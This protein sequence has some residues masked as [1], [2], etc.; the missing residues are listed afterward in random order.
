MSQSC[1]INKCIRI[2]RGLCDC[3]QQNLCLQHLI[4]HNASLVSQLNPLTDEVNALGDRLKTLNIQKTIGDSREKLEQWRE[5]CHNKIDCFFEEK[6]QE[7]DQLVNEKVGQQREELNRINLKITEL[8]N[9]QE[10]TR[11]DIDLLTFTIR[12]LERNMNK[13]EQ[14]CFTINTRPLII[15]DTLISIEKVTEHELDLSTLSP[16]YKTIHRPEE[17]SRLLTGND[18]Y[19]LVHQYPNLCLF[20]RE[21]NIVKQMLWS[22]GKINDMCWSSTLD[23]F[24]VLGIN[25]IYLINENTMSIDNMQTSEERLWL[26]CTCSDTVLFA[27]TNEWG[28]S[29]MKFKLLPAIEL[30]K[31]WKYPFTCA[32]DEAITDI[33]KIQLNFLII[34]ILIYK[35]YA[36]D[37]R[38]HNYSEMTSILQDLAFRYPTK[39]SLVEIGKSQGGRSLW[40]MT[41]SAYAPNEHILLRPEV[42][43]IGNMHGNE[44]VGLE[45]LLY[46][47]EYLLTSNDTQVYQLM[48]QSRIWIMPS[49][50]P[51]GLEESIY[52][53]CILNAGRNTLNNI[54]LNRNFPDYYGATLSSSIRAQETNAIISWLANISFVLSANYHGGSFVVNTPFDRFYVER[55]STSD[56]DDIYQM[57]AHSYINRT[58][59]INDYCSDEQINSDYVTRGADWYEVSGGMQDY[60]YFNYGT[61]EITIEVSCCKYP[62]SNLLVNYWNYNRDAMIEYLLQAQ[63]GVKGLILNENFQPIPSTQVMINNRKPVVKVTSLG[64]FWRILLPGTYTLKV[65]YKNIQIYSQE[66]TIE[67]SLSPLNLTIIISSATY[68]PYINMTSKASLTII[69][70]SMNSL[71]SIHLKIKKTAHRTNFLTSKALQQPSNASFVVSPSRG[72]TFITKRVHQ[73]S[74][75]KTSNKIKSERLPSIQRHPTQSEFRQYSTN[76]LTS[77]R[78]VQFL[79]KYNKYPVRP[80]KQYITKSMSTT[81]TKKPVPIVSNKIPSSSTTR[82]S[83]DSDRRA[84]KL[85][86]SPKRNEV[87]IRSKND[88][89]F[90]NVSAKVNS[91]ANRDYRPGGGQI[92]IRDQPIQW[93]ASSKVNSFANANWTSPPPR[94]NVKTEKLQW[95]A[96]S[97]VD[98]MANIDYKPSGGENVAIRDEKIDVSHVTPRVDCGFV[99]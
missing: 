39:A 69:R 42:K 68:P 85:W 29:I 6:C 51:D 26:S 13:I 58:K 38:Y 79:L 9:A 7:L 36:I 78:T 62:Q 92:S 71:S 32:K 83:S 34:S 46:L 40:A 14:T 20:D 17:S 5:D 99:D 10:T 54:D 22:Y 49:M 75:N 84:R 2:S 47:I 88:T 35:N 86:W 48:N 94:V 97:K 44:V 66:I 57:I 81:T 93:Q 73:Q 24:I 65:L 64:E 53:D 15:D 67:N 72:S 95:N 4:E 76:D 55:I 82:S 74:L 1:S 89:R 12:R 25:H 27:S 61:I 90:K 16:V 77:K 19:L 91:L 21:M 45:I 8:I 56:D 96:Q 31:E 60:G 28:S 11:Q 43:Y 70:N 30:I 18:R 52:G 59:Q 50:N 41:L 80:N 98:S 63:R 23:R 33:F 37:Y 87:G 3:C